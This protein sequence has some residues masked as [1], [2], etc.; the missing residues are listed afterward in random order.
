MALLAAAVA[1]GGSCERFADGH[2]GSG[3]GTACTSD[4]VCQASSCIDG[5]CV[6]PCPTEPGESCP[7]GTVC[8]AESCHVPLAVGFIYPGQ[9]AQ[10]EYTLSFDRGR[11][12]VKDALAYASLAFIEDVASAPAVNDAASKFLAQ[13]RPVMVGVA[14]AYGPLL[15]D[16]A[17][18]HPEA[19]LF[20]AGARET[21]ENLVSFDA[22]T[23]QAYYLA[24]IAAGSKTTSRR[25]GMIGSTYSPATIASINGFAL[26]ARSVDPT[27]VV[28]L[29]WIGAPHD[30]DPPVQGKSRER[31]FTENLIANGADI[32][33]HTLDN[34]IPVYTVAEDASTVLAIGANVSDVCSIKPSR[35]LGSVYYNWGPLLV[36]LLDGYHRQSLPPSRAVLEGIRVSNTESVFGFLLSSGILGAPA[37][38]VE[39]DAALTGLASDDGV[40]RVFD[41]P[42]QST[43]QCEAATGKAT[44]LADGERLDD[45]G[46]FEMCWLVQ[47]IVER[48]GATDV[49]AMVP[50]LGDCAPP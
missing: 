36:S 31:V 22:R 25:L 19:T 38:Q 23:Y 50:A 34:N 4:D 48:Q 39:L 45:M 15:A 27:I 33:A 49:P 21:R 30:S 20:V 29:L 9:V 6:I 14:P 44:C 2:I 40:G 24:G 17:A 8:A 12:D 3:L 28:E 5:V 1:L 32:I 35:C 11:A 7:Q 10:E 41:G 46:L 18:D 47:G 37:I 26:G 43:G 16:F 42:I 13:E